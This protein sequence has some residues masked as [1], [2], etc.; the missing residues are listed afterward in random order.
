[1]LTVADV[2]QLPI[3]ESSR[4]VAGAGGLHRT[5]AWVHNVGVPD[6]ANWLNG[7][8]LALTTPNNLPDDPAAQV[9]YV[10]ALLRKEVAA[11]GVSVG[12]MID[13]IP[14]RMIE[15]A[16]A[17]NFPLLEVPYEVR[18]VDIA[19]AANERIAQENMALVTR[20]FTIHQTLT[21]LVLEG[22]DIPQ[23]A[24]TLAGLVNQSVSIETDQFE[25]LASVNIAPVDEARRYTQEEGRTDPRLVRALEADVLPEIRRTRRPVFIPQM[26]HVG[27]EMERIL[28]PIVVHG[29]I[30]G[31]VWIIAD[32]RPLNDLD[33]L[34]IE[35]GATIAALMM[36]YQES[37]QNAEASLRGSLLTRLIQGEAGREDLLTDQ[38][39][40]YG[41]D[42]RQ[43]F[44]L[45]LVD[46]P[47]SGP[48][49]LVGLSQR[50]NRLIA[51]HFSAIAGQF[52]GQI[53]VMVQD[54][55]AE[56]S[57]SQSVAEGILSESAQ[58]EGS[59]GLR[60]G[61]SGI[62]RGANGVPAAYDQCREAVLIGRRL[63]Q[64]HKILRF[65]DLGYLHTL[66]HAGAGALAGNPHV[67]GLKAL[68][69]EQQA[70]LFNTLE[71]YL[72][73]GG[74]GVATA[75]ALHIH[76]STLNYRLARIEDV[77]GVDLANP[78]A[79]LNLQIALKLLRLF[80]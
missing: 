60:V 37:V 33:R 79:R 3:L 76:R 15:V 59:A 44:R 13:H 62:G 6:A 29:E 32:D 64:T 17:H 22:G 4:L 52:A 57:P 5:I 8:E 41:I 31:Y 69:E 10:L 67:T 19:R 50:F 68:Q 2:L 48:R 7:G 80:D 78:A 42:I 70:D 46:W 39:L 65:D 30:Y 16:E 26:P 21:R 25:A 36:L 56:P 24:S 43:P 38:A 23:L 61:M 45:L 18:F 73:L 71:V 14:P 20:A 40:R 28:A 12:R 55:T 49:R 66:Y 53:V 27:L 75:E 77:C 58:Y 72:D 11:L 47:E 34:A 54:N 35:S 74:N 1:M 63:N 9:E 51:T